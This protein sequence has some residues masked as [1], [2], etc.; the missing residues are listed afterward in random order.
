VSRNTEH[1]GGEGGL[2]MGEVE[3]KGDINLNLI[4]SDRSR[5]LNRLF[6]EI[7][8]KRFLKEIEE[9]KR[10]VEGFLKALEVEDEGDD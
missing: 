3:E 10:E 7:S 2:E 4:F 6:P 5:D 8:L 1:G 9:N